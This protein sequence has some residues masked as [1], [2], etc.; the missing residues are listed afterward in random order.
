VYDLVWEYTTGQPW[1]V[2]ALAYEACFRN[3]TGKDRKQPITVQMIEAV[4]RELILRRDTHIDQL[5][6]KLKEGR[7]KKVIEPMLSGETLQEDAYHDDVEYCL[8][9]GLVKK[10]NHGLDIANA[11]YRE[12]IPR[13]LGFMTQ[14]SLESREGQFFCVVL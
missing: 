3:K 12:I 4:K 8:D 2:N 5:A 1:L 14:L 11:I 6:D 10:T 13:V 7:V 9:L